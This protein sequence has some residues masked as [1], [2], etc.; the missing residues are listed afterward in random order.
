[1]LFRS[2]RVVAGLEE[3]NSGS[4][5]IDGQDVSRE[6]VAN[7]KLG[8]VFQSYALFP[9]INIIGNVMYG[10]NRRQFSIGQRTRRAM[11]M[12]EL[13]GIEEQAFK[14]P[15]QLLG[16]QQ[17]RVALARALALSLQYCI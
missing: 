3:K 4:V 12:L 2:L 6:P 11:E 14:Y 8:I 10:I 7:R 15:A 17:Q 16:G 13:V 1:M 9:N 5:W